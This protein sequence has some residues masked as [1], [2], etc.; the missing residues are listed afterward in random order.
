MQV[1]DQLQADI[2]RGNRADLLLKDDLLSGAFDKL[3]A[4]YLAAWKATKY[5]DTDGRERL[6]QSIQIV[7]KVRTHL[8][9]AVTDGK[10]AQAEVDHLRTMGERKKIFGVV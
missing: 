5:N 4:E 9:S 3:E 8:Q 7:G 1:T 10:L 2:A 6:W